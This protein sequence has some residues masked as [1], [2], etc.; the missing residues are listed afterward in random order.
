MSVNQFVNWFGGIQET[1]EA[2]QE[3]YTYSLFNPVAVFEL[4]DGGYTLACIREQNWPPHETA[5]AVER[6]VGY[7][8]VS[9]CD[10]VLGAWK[11]Y[12]GQP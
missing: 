7:K 11:P 2:A 1:I 3:F 5:Q 10:P 8:M 4:P 9:Y 6:L 12:E